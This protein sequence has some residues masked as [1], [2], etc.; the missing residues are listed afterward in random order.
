[1]TKPIDPAGLLSTA[2]ADHRAGRHGDAEHGYRAILAADPR[3]FDA[4]QLLGALA[5]GDGRCEEGIALLRSAVAVRADHAASR[6]NL[7]NALLRVGRPEEALASAE[8]ACSLD[9]MHAGNQHARGNALAALGRDAEA[10][11]AQVAAIRAE[12]GHR[13]RPA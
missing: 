8:H 12:P 10:I 9:P 1:M 11:D 2:V 3:H 5:I 13:R 7:A 4:L 6:R